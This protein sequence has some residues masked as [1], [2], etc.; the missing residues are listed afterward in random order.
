MTYLCVSIFVR[1]LLQAR[2]EIAEAAE[3]G[4]DMVELR[5]DTFTNPSHVRELVDKCILPAIVTC[6]ASWEGGECALAEDERLALLAAAARGST[7][8]V[9]VEFAAVQKGA[10]LPQG[11]PVVVSAHDFQGRP[12]RLGNLLLEMN[13]G[14]GDICKIA[15]MARSVRDCV[16]AFE[17]LRSQSKRTIAICMGEAG[18]PTR[19]LAKKF[20][21]VLS[22]ASA[23]EGRGTASGQVTL[24]EMKGT[25][26]WDHIN[27][28]TRVYGVVGE[29]IAHSMSPALHNAAFAAVGHNGVY[30]PLLVQGSYESFKAFM[31]T[32]LGFEPL[33]LSGLSVTIPHKENA[34][35]Y[36]R[37]KGAEIEPLA[38]AIG[39]V[40][41]IKIS[42][43]GGEVKLAGYNSDYAAILDSVCAAL[44]I[45]RPQLEG[46]RVAV[47]G[48]GGTGRTAVAALAH[49]GAGVTVF[50]RT[51]GRAAALASEFG[52]EAKLVAAEPLEA[53]AGREFDVII[54]T[55]SIGMSPRVDASVFDIGMPK[56]TGHSVVFDAIYNPV[57]T[58][59]LRQATVA[60]ARTIGGV[61]MFVRQA[62]RQFE[63]WL[64]TPA[65]RELMRQVVMERLQP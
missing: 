54:Q 39:A 20:G 25:Y 29:P 22:F 50:N 30:L 17:I 42:H 62:A 65:P 26:R 11:V 48:A 16:E 28:R 59:L 52:G 9:D 23:G 4:A 63:L 32:W 13:R 24:G 40:N 53:L 14:R 27:P 51:V 64:D 12:E 5:I 45:N 41:T 21:A 58:R 57:E 15:W 33:D 31:E 47:I 7:R 19:V 38:E 61:E 43:A 1:T 49:Y 35:R 3:G 46:L 6:R 8:Y 37:E 60:G 2:Q 44:C 55:T 18:L 34:L 10:E 36:L 56:L